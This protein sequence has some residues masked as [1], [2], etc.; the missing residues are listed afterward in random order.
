MA[1]A[2]VRVADEKYARVADAK[3]VRRAFVPGDDV[4]LLLPTKHNKLEVAWKGP[5]T[6]LECCGPVDYRI[7]AG[8]KRKVHVNLLNRYVQRDAPRTTVAVVIEEEEV[9][10]IPVINEERNKIPLVCPF[11]C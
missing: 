6:V 2:N 8:H 4:L 5:Y 3:S 7:Q 11:D 10:E 9:T 1:R